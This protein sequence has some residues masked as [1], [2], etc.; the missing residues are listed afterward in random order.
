MIETLVID[1]VVRKVKVQV[2]QFLF[3]LNTTSYIFGPL[4][5]DLIIS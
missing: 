5:H 2:L 1:L 4:A 3:V